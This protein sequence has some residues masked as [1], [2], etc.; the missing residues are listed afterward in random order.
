[1]IESALKNGRNDSVSINGGWNPKN[2][3]QNGHPS[4]FDNS[5]QQ[6]SIVWNLESR[7]AYAFLA[8]SCLPDEA[9]AKTVKCETK[10]AMM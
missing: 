4:L 1:M 6:N 10:V 2:G 7:G 5:F 9:I 3:V 8:P